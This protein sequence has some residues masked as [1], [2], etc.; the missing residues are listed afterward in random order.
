MVIAIINTLLI[1][2]DTDDKHYF[3]S[4]LYFIIASFVI[5]PE[6]LIRLTEPYALQTV[7]EI[8]CKKKGTQQ[9]ADQSLDS[10]LNSAMNIEFVCIIIKGVN[11]YM[12]LALDAVSG[13]ESRS[14]ARSFMV[15]K[16]K[17]GD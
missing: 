4:P 16:N 9:Y 6:F 10:F 7:K 3:E 2:H 15:A 14:S 8:V 17:K 13:N 12:D 5:F 1:P 11:N